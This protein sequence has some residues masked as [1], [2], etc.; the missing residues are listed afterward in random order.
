MAFLE[1]IAVRIGLDP[2]ELRKGA[3]TAIRD[4]RAVKSAARDARDG[5]ASMGDGFRQFGT[6]VAGV[7]VAV[8]AATVATVNFVKSGADVADVAGKQAQAL[9]LTTKE[10]GRLSFAA[11]QGEVDNAALGAGITKLNKQIVAGR[12]GQKSAVALFGAL[13]IRLRDANGRAFKTEQILEA[14]AFRFS[15][16]RDGAN[17]SAFAVQLFGKSG[18][19]L[20]PTLNGGVKGLRDLGRQAEQLGLVFTKQ[21]TI[22]ADEFGDA[23]GRSSAAVKGLRSQIA[24]AFAPELTAL[25]DQFTAA[26]VRNRASLVDLAARG[27]RTVVQLALDFFNAFSGKDALVA[28]QTV[29]A[30]R[31]N[32]LAMRAAIA[33]ALTEVVLPL[34]SQLKAFLDDVARGLNEAF[35]TNLTGA[36]LAVAL[37]AG[38]FLGFFTLI[39]GAVQTLVPLLQ[40]LGST[41]VLLARPLLALASSGPVLGFFAKLIG[42][43]TSFL[44]VIAGVIGWPVLLVAGVVAAGAAIFIFWDD[45]KAA[46]VATYDFIIDLFSRIGGAV[47]RALGTAKD[48]VG[49]FTGEKE[50][51]SVNLQRRARGGPINGPG[52]S[53]SD[54]I[55]ARVS[56]GEFVVRAAAVRKLGVNFMDKI[57]QGIVP[58][59]ADGGMVGAAAGRPINLNIGGSNFPANMGEEVVSGLVRHARKSG[60]LSPV[61]APSWS[62]RR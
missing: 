58:G 13:G 9:G 56:R 4:L 2:K 28:N 21:Q 31:D 33:G 51:G 36:E 7:A 16:M 47:S 52:T 38:K 25:A 40:L 24:L 42:G 6:V 57:N 35:G 34:L 15:R 26:I 14:I 11:E 50:S 61:R 5:L 19:A 46:A 62:G 10:Y 22:I 44:T 17:K 37:F 55:L 41:F 45:I 59:F 12:A 20:I 1:E 43:A 18:A 3:A 53:T 29:L 49:G 8:S 48:F 30:I 54:S 39:G 32:V 60:L 23:L 27:F